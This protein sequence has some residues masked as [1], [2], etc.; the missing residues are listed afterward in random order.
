MNPSLLT[1]TLAVTFTV[2]LPAQ[3]LQVIS[4]IGA[5]FFNGNSASDIM[6]G[7]FS[8][9]TRTQQ[10]DNNLVGAGLPL[11][12][13]IGWRRDGSANAG[14]AK[15]TDVTIIMSH[16]DFA[17]VTNNF[18]ANYK[19]APQTVFAQKPVNLPDWNA[20]AP[21]TPAPF[22]LRFPLDAPFVYNQSDA[23]LW[24]VLNDNNPLGRYTQDW[25][26]VSFPHTYGATPTQ[27]GAGCT[28]PNG[29][30]SHRTAVRADATTLE[31][32]FRVDQAPSS[33]QVSM[34]FGFSNPSLT[35]PGLCSTVDVSSIVS[36]PLGTAGV[37]G[38][39]PFAVA[40]SAPWNPQLAGL[41]IH[42][43]ALALDATQ[44][45][46]PVSVSGGLLS[47]IP[48]SAGPGAVNIKRIY[49][50]SSTSAA[51]GT[52]PSNS[53]VPTVYSL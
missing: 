6:F 43:Q 15:T 52:G 44:P 22:D 27:T 18:A 11:I 41:P 20:P 50:T 32:G 28:T 37:G 49:H 33:A 16:A 23:L 51:T 17:T 36:V 13:S 26:S 9:S 29:T 4:P 7:N 31:V 8:A 3:N 5:E 19:D 40:I 38:D 21:T 42:T 24:D 48:T 1:I 46:I 35:L 30:M 25:I 53:G 12:T 10:I 47:P 14:A 34:L 45:G 2:S 39:V